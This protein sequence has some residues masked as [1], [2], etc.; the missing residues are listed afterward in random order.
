MDAATVAAGY[1]RLTARLTA[2]AEGEDNI[3][4]VLVIGSRARS[5]HPADAWSDLDVL[6]LA[7]DPAPLWED[8]GWVQAIGR[9]WLTF[10]EPTPDGRGFERRVLFEGGLDVDFV[11]QHVA[12]LDA[13]LA[14]GIPPDVA[15]MLRRGVRFLVDKDG[16]AARFEA[17]PL[18]T[19]RAD[20][21]A[22]AEFLNQVNDFW[23]P[24]VWTAKHLRRGE[25]W[26]AK[27]GCDSYLKGLLRQMLE[28]HAQATRGGHVDTW[29]RGRF[30]EEWADSRAVA[31]LPQAFAHY[32]A[33]D[34]WQALQVTLELYRRLS[35]ETA[36]KWGFGYPTAGAEA[37]AALVQGLAAGRD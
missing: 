24:T 19:L 32:D 3:R 16:Y 28:W 27:G 13:M 5:D 12:G 25:L 11:P 33:E 1:D 4:V 22:E 18:P 20:P 6:L 9:P 36:A 2:W 30:L 29:M 14:H 26:W 17:L 35:L 31:A 34:I 7:R 37:A 8:A 15:D 21:P 23:Y 10:L